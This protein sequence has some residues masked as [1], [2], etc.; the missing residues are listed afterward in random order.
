MSN[1]VRLAFV[2]PSCG[3]DTASLLIGGKAFEILYGQAS[4]YVEVNS[5]SVTVSVC[6]LNITQDLPQNSSYYTIVYYDGTAESQFSLLLD[7]HSRWTSQVD[8]VGVRVFNALSRPQ[9]TSLFGVGTNCYN[10]LYPELAQLKN[11]TLDLPIVEMTTVSF[12]SQFLVAE[13]ADVTDPR[14]L[15]DLSHAHDFT[16]PPNSRYTLIL[17]PGDRSQLD[18]GSIGWTFLC[19]FRGD[20]QFTYLSPIAGAFFLALAAIGVYQFS[21]QCFGSSL[22]HASLPLNSLDNIVSNDERKEL[23]LPSEIQS[24]PSK[25]RVMSLDTMRGISLFIMIFV[26]YGGGGYWF[27]NH[28]VWNGLTVADLVFPW[29]IF[30]MGASMALSF[31]NYGKNLDLDL[32][33]LLPKVLTRGLNLVALGL[34]MNNGYDLAFW[35]IPGVLWRFGVSFLV[36]GSILLFVP[37]FRADAHSSLSHPALVDITPFLF[38]WTVALCM[39]LVWLIVTF[40]VTIPG[41]GAGYVGPGGIGD[42]GVFHDCTGGAAGWIDL[43][44]FGL[45]HIYDSPTCKDL[46]RT[47]SYDPE[48][49]LGVLT[50]AFM[51]FLG[52]AT[53]RILVTYTEHSQRLHRLVLHGVSEMF[54]AACLCGFAQNGGAIPVNKNLWSLSFVLL[55]AGF[56]NILLCVVYVLVDLKKWWAGAP[57]IYMGM[58]SIVI[59]IGSETYQGNFPFSWSLDIMQASHH[60]NLLFMHLTGPI[61]WSCVAYVMY[62]KDM[63]FNL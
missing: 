13:S 7:D 58:N 32:R 50:S 10:C 16:F 3:S 20:S 39:V 14:M 6:S 60:G 63:F 26:N 48:G 43:K 45:H 59:Y 40:A 35:R 25:E 31:K 2:A 21:S 17:F 62:K 4:D 29:F 18:D 12:A 36:V 1:Q 52:V 38:Q 11:P 47:G 27:F 9:P 37:K 33:V 8:A 53:G 57:F 56:G 19:E 51:C 42:W 49:L 54:L 30:M 34:F 24:K 46:Y 28:S 22:S 61:M 44:V 55:L 41:C 15:I 23:F 5:T